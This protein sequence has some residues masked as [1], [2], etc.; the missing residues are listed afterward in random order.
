[1]KKLLFILVVLIL[2][3]CHSS[4]LSIS[5]IERVPKKVQA[6]IEENSTLQMINNGKGISYIVFRSKG[7]VS[8]NLETQDDTLIVKLDVTNQQDNPMEQHVFKLTLDPNY[9]TIDIQINGASTT[10]DNVTGI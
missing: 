4:S 1:M 6:V 7:T 9:D 5:K 2:T 8:A 3:A 10:I